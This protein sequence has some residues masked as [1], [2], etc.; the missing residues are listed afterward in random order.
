MRFSK[1]WR[2]VAFTGALVGSAGLVVAAATATGAYFNDTQS[3]TVSGNFGSIHV[4]TSGGTG[5]DSLDFSMTNM[6]PG[7]WQTITVHYKNTGLNTEDV[8][9]VFNTADALHA[10][11]NLGQYG[12]AKI[13]SGSNT[14]FYS[15][16]LSDG[17]TAALGPI[18]ETGGHCSSNP[19][20]GSNDVALS[21]AGEGTANPGCW[22]IPDVLKL[23]SNVQPGQAGTMTF[24]FAP[25]PK[26][27]SAAAETAQFFCYPLVQ[28][29]TQEDQ[30]CTTNSPQYGLPYQI[31]ATQP[32]VAPNNPDNTTPTP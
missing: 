8:Y 32:G 2:L 31:V 21:S 4:T 1:R 27:S 5:T 22:P 15:T 17:E 10:V 24:S 6:L 30:T 3:G 18:T 13:T 23:A 7:Q 25:G 16:N 12:E 14:I 19:P 20:A 11:N 28:G 26:W 9:L 29:A